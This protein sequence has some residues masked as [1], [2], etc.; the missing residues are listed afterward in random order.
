MDLKAKVA[1]DAINERVKNEA[2]LVKKVGSIVV[3]DITKNGQIQQ[4]W[5]MKSKFNRM[6][7]LI[8]YGFI[9]F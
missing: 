8:D 4:S 7:K 2:S 1:F 6:T 9:G 5:S 3:F